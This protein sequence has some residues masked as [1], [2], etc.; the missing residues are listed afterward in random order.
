MAVDKLKHPKSIPG[1]GG[2]PVDG[3][4]SVLDVKSGGALTTR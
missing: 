1:S 3:Q 2:V 4:R